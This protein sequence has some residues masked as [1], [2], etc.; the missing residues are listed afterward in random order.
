MRIATH[1]VNA[2]NGRLPV[3]LRW[4]EETRPDVACLQELRVPED[5]FPS[6]AI[7]KKLPLTPLQQD[8]RPVAEP[9]GSSVMRPQ[10][11]V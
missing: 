6:D 7:R 4:L 11:F 2:V 8:L 10:L 3:L 9:V 1:N 5:K